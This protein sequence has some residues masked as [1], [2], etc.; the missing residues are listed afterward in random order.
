M[1]HDGIGSV[2]GSTGWFLVK[3]GQY[4]AVF[5][6]TGGGA[7]LKNFGVAAVPGRGGEGWGVHPWYLVELC[8]FNFMILVF[9]VSLN[10]SEFIAKT[11]IF[12]DLSPYRPCQKLNI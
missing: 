12:R 11:Y 6:G 8:Q 5:D 7:V 10:F 3:K 1:I 9:F 2:K 4:G